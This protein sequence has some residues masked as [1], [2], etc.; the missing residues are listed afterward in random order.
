MF[1]C[2]GVE[3]ITKSETLKRKALHD[4]LL[5]DSLDTHFNTLPTTMLTLI[6]F[7]TQDSIGAIYEPIVNGNPW[8]ILYFLLLLLVISV[9]LMNLITAVLVEHSITM[10]S[11]DREMTHHSTKMRIR[12]LMPKVENLFTELDSNGDG[13]L[14]R[15]EVLHQTKGISFPQEFSRIVSPETLLDLYEAL[16]GDQSGQVDMKEFVEGIV[17]LALSEV[18]IETTK[19]LHHLRTQKGKIGNVEQQLEN[20]GKWLACLTGV[21]EPLQGRASR[22]SSKQ[23]PPPICSQRQDSKSTHSTSGYPQD[24]VEDGESDDTAI[25]GA[26]PALAFNLT[27]MTRISSPCSES[28]KSPVASLMETPR[29]PDG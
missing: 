17:S 10:A 16:D 20:L 27:A 5:R 13:Q 15:D 22:T 6:R 25:E 18:P 14:T 1:A 2:A 19:M 21:Q 12:A 9:T 8:L 29:T 7:T 24:V 4:H 11:H 28:P 3:L 23:T 26:R